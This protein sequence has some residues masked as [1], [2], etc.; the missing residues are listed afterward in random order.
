MARGLLH[1]AQALRPKRQTLRKKNRAQEGMPRGSGSS[2]S[3][4]ARRLVMTR[5]MKPRRITVLFQEIV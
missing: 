5:D 2:R 1:A 3:A 4:R